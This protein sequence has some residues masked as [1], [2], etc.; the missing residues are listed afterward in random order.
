MDARA[1]LHTFRQEVRDQI[2]ISITKTK[3]RIAP[4]P[5]GTRGEHIAFGKSDDNFL[6]LLS[7]CLVD[8]TFGST[9]K[10]VRDAHRRARMVKKT[11]ITPLHTF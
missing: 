7:E 10:S 8:L 6:E 9:E 5:L 1:H 11:K 3:R 4:G 2:K